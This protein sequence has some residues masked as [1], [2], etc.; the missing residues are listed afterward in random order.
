PPPTPTLFPYTTLFRSLNAHWLLFAGEQSAIGDQRRAVDGSAG[1]DVGVAQRRRVAEGNTAFDDP[2][3][4]SSLGS[5]IRHGTG[6][7]FQKDR[8]STRLNSSHV[9]IS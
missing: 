7:C 4:R 1:A 2:P 5:V 3:A 8:K 6:I 9:S